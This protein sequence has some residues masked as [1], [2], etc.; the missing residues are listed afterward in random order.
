MGSRVANEIWLRRVSVLGSRNHAVA[1]VT[2][3]MGRV[4]RSRRSEMLPVSWRVGIHPG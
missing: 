3:A 2:M 1:A 4:R